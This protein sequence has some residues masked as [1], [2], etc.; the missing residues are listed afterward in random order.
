MT[1]SALFSDTF[2]YYPKY[3]PG[4]LVAESLRGAAFEKESG[5]QATNKKEF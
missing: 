5:C 3:K 2:L 1:R 4:S